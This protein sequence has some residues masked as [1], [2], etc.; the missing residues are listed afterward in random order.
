MTTMEWQNL[1]RVAPAALA[2]TRAQLHWAAQVLAACADRWIEPRADDGHT[3]MEWDAARGALVGQATP[4]GAR[5]ALRVAD[6][7]LIG[8]EELPLTG[9]S[10]PEAMSWADRQLAAAAGEAPRGAAARE[11]DMPA[12]AVAQAAPFAP[13]G[14]ALAELARW[15]ADGDLV[16]RDIAARDE[17]ATAVRCWPHHF[18]I[19]A[20]LYLDRDRPPESAR[21]I[22]FGLSPGDQ[23]HAEPYF[24][25]TPSPI[26]VD[27]TFPPL[28]SG[29]RWQRSGFTGAVLLASDLLQQ[30]PPDGQ[31]E[32]ARAFFDAAFAVGRN[33][34]GRR[35]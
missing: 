18:D 12:H 33:L 26:E 5:L 34:I 20:I 31:H 17:G 13:D 16:L 22:G 35:R 14:E 23:H 19:A 21:Q 32:R 6:L 27:V 1:G 28:P 8:R 4:S 24:Y 30:G 2:D 29:G 3:A 11:Y 7:T 25:V 10:L 15:Y 9:H